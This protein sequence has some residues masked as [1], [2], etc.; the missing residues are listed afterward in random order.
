MYLS[1]QDETRKERSEIISLFKCLLIE[2]GIIGACLASISFPISS[3]LWEQCP[4][5]FLL[6]QP[7][8]HHLLLCTSTS[9]NLWRCSTHILIFEPKFLPQP[10][11]FLS[12]FS[13]I[14]VF[15]FCQPLAL[16]LNNAKLGEQ[17]LNWP[18]V[19]HLS[20]AILVGWQPISSRRDAL[21]EHTLLISLISV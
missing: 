4:L 17:N 9:L 5:L 13:S 14:I 20:T 19:P 1:L 8:T 21:A 7:Q 12:C 16:A 2:G 15:C 18:L 11:A 10:R 6:F 3:R